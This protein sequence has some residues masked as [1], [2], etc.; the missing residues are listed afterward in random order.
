MDMHIYQLCVPLHGN[1]KTHDKR[2]IFYTFQV[3]KVKI[4]QLYVHV[5][6]AISILSSYICHKN[7]YVWLS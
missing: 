1:L 4:V 5:L 7:S 6:R 3:K 2:F